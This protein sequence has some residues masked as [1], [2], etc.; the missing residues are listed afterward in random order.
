[1]QELM[2]GS[3]C[4]FIGETFL[5]SISYTDKSPKLQIVV[6]LENSGKGNKNMALNGSVFRREKMQ[7]AGSRF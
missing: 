3:S 2:I 5:I 1:M 6:R 4:L 7:A